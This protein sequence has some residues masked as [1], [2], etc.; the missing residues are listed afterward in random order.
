V[1]LVV[2][3]YD[4]DPRD[5]Y[6]TPEVRRHLAALDSAFPFWFYFAD[7]DTYSLRLLALCVCRVVKVPGGSTPDKEDLKRF[8]VEHTLA[9]NHLCDRFLLGDDVKAAATKESLRQLVPDDGA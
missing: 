7:P 8:M 5:L 3:G 4:D 9:L 6:G 2:E 1:T